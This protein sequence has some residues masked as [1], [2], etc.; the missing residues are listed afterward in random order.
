MAVIMPTI[1]DTNTASRI[2]NIVSDATEAASTNHAIVAIS[3]ERSTAVTDQNRN[4]A[5][6]RRRKNS[7]MMNTVDAS[8]NISAVCQ[9]SSPTAQHTTAPT[10]PAS[11]AHPRPTV[12]RPARTWRTPRSSTVRESPTSPVAIALARTS[13]PEIRP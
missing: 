13:P 7:S 12:C 6:S 4:D 5:I 11:T 10:T 1:C 3:V 9:P 8:P 2:W